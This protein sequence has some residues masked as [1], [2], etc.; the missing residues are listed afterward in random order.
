V[1]TPPSANDA[2]KKTIL[3]TR[4]GAHPQSWRIECVAR[5]PLSAKFARFNTV[6]NQTQ[7]SA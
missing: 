7:H 5:P 4:E 6:L 1:T 2:R 3:L